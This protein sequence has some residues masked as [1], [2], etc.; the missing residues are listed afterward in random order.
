MFNN[1][2]LC[3]FFFFFAS[4]EKELARIVIKKED[5]D[6]IVS[7]A[8][9]LDNMNLLLCL[10]LP[11]LQFHQ[12]QLYTTVS[13]ISVTHSYGKLKLYDVI[14]IYSTRNSSALFTLTSVSIFSILFSIHFLRC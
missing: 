13:S 7:Y 8:S 11:L 6:L 9:N 5:V 2:M 3:F 10:I 14:K 12:P 1:I 4:R